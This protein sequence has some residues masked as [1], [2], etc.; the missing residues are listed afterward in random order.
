MQSLTAPPRNTLTATQVTTLLT[1]DTLSVTGGLELLNS[2]NQLISDISDDLV[3]GSVK[4]A[5]YADVHGTCTLQIARELAWGKDRVRPYMTLTANGVSARF[6][7]GVFICTSPKTPRG[8]TPVFYDVDGFDLIHLLQTTGPGDTYVVTAGTSYLTAVQ[9][10]ITASGVN[11][12]L[13]LDGTLGSTTLP[14]TMVWALI[15]PAPSWLRIINDLLAAIN[16]RGLWADQDGTFRS[17]PYQNPTNAPVE[18]TFDTANKTTNLI[19]EDR[20]MS[21]DV[22]GI[23]N[24]WRFIRTKMT[25]QPTEGAGIYTVTNQSTGATSIDAVGRTI[26]KV[27][28][29]DAANQSS[30]VSQGDRIVAEDKQES[31]TFDVAMDPLPIAGHFDVVQLIDAGR[32]D[33]CVVTNWELPLD[34]SPGQ[35]T[36][37]AV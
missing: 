24:W 11:A 34:G 36:L 6:N 29:L 25:T 32:S 33:K 28:Y 9:A 5:N 23:P 2:S 16:Y 10:V 12:S 37:K 7:L 8:I 30:L 21:A 22:W 27:V 17:G 13:Q 15:S 20:T 18:W 4:R 31:R 1:G 26:R 19:G 14:T 35:W 3:G